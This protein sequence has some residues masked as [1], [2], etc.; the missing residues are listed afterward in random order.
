MSAIKQ[1]LRRMMGLMLICVTVSF[2]VGFG[3]GSVICGVIAYGYS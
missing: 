2:C 1:C 3:I